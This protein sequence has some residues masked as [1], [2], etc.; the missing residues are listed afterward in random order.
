MTVKRQRFYGWALL[1]CLGAGAVCAPPIPGQGSAPRQGAPAPDQ[2]GAADKPGW[3]LTFRDEFDGDAVDRAKWS[4]EDPWGKERNRELQAYV[5][6]ACQ[7]RGGL[8]RLVADKRR[9][10]YDGKDREYTSGL[11]TTYRKFSQRY[12][13]F[14]IRCRV[15]RGQGLWPAFWLLPDPLDWPPEI[16][17]LEIKGQE[18]TRI[19]LTHHWED[20][21]GRNHWEQTAWAGPDFSA[22]YHVIALEWAPES[23]KW[24]VDGVERRYAV[25]HVPATKM[26]LMVNLAVGG[27]FL[28][29]P[30]RETAFPSAFEVDYVRAY[31]KKG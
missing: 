20:P 11:L 12:G 9:A 23:L 25:R 18:P 5:A 8:L 21:P 15:P 10:R 28:G 27:E 22:D 26:F 14:E 1:A 16:D 31:E 19:Y 24:Y 17:V 6:D 4:L 30:G 29:P 7:V 2:G 13:W 3:R